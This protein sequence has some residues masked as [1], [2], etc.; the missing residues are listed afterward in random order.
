MAVCVVFLFGS[1][2]VVSS[3]IRLIMFSL[4]FPHHNSMADQLGYLT[5]VAYW[6]VLEGGL[7]IMAA[8]LPTLGPL[9][10]QGSGQ[11]GG[12]AVSLA[13]NL[14]RGWC[15]MTRQDTPNDPRSC[16]NGSGS[17]PR[18]SRPKSYIGRIGTT[19]RKDRNGSQSGASATEALV[20]D[21][22]QAH[23]YPPDDVKGKPV[24]TVELNDFATSHSQ[25]LEQ[26]SVLVQKDITVEH[27]TI[28]AA[29][30]K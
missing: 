17:D 6:G 7:S 24:Q 28:Q 10:S 15:I 21:A 16:Y 9:L 20:N 27:N 26:Q 8:C 4:V 19:I 29:T 30:R 3:I 13:Y 22:Y 25:S 11:Q 5:T 14:E 18:S 23:A 1:L 12:W 2:T